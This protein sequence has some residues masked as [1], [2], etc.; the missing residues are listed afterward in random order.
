MQIRILAG[1]ERLVMA[2]AIASLIIAPAGAAAPDSKGKPASGTPLTS[3]NDGEQQVED[4]M[5]A[6]EPILYARPNSS[7]P[8]SSGPVYG[9][10]EASSWSAGGVLH[11]QVGSFDLTR[12]MP[13]LPNELRSDN[14]LDKATT[15][16]FLMQVR[17]KAFTDGTFDELK[18]AIVAHGGSIVGEMPVA[19]FLVRMTPGAHDAVKD[20]SSIV[21]LLP[22]QPAFKLSPEIGRVPLLDAVRAASSV[23]SLRLKLFPGES[24]EA[25][26]AS[27]KGLGLEVKGS[28]GD[29][30]FV[31]ADRS[32]LAAIASL[33]QVFMIEEVLPIF[34]RSEET[35][36]TVQT[37]KWN[38][39]A[40]PY[41]DAGVDGGGL[42]KTST[43]DDQILMILDNGIQLDA[44]DLSESS[45]DPGLDSNNLPIVG[46]RKVAFYGTTV[47]F[48]G[49]GDL[50]G[51]DGNTTSG[52]THGHSVAAVAL[53]NATRVLPTLSGHL[54]YGTPYRGTDTSG[55]FWGLDG[56]A[57][58]ARLVAYDGQVTPL[59]GRCDDVTQVP[60]PL[61]GLSPLY[62]GNL[63][64]LLPDAYT[65]KG[66]RVVNFSWGSVANAF[67]T[68]AGDIDAFLVSRSDA[69]VFVAA[70]NSGRD[71]DLNRI[72]D[73]NTIGAPATAKNIISV[74]AARTANDLGGLD[75]PTR[76]PLRD[77][78]NTRAVLSSNGP[79]TIFS[80]RIAPLLMAPGQDIGTMGLA[81]EFHCR[82]ND[83]N[84]YGPVEC[85]V[86]V[87]QGAGAVTGATTSYASAAAAGAGLVVRDYFAQGFYPDG[88]NTNS[89]NATDQVSTISGP[90]LKAVLV[91][92]AEW[93][94]APKSN[95]PF[96]AEAPN[97]IT[98]LTRKF[99][100]NREQGFGRIVL[101]NA[102]PL[103]TYPGA[104]S[105]LIV[106]DGGPA[107]AGLVNSTT[108]DLLAPYLASQSYALN[109]CDTSQRLAIAIAWNDP[110]I[111]D[112]I[113]R[114]LDLEVTAPSGRKYLG[115]FFTDDTDD[116]AVIA[117]NE[118][119][120]FT[121]HPWPPDSGPLAVDAGPWSLPSS[122]CTAGAH[123]DHNN[124][125]EAVFLSPDSR[126]NGIADIPGT[127]LNEA[128]DNQ[129]EQGVWNVVV[130]NGPVLAQPDAYSI[131]IAGGICLGSAA[132]IQRVLASNQLA[133]AVLSCNDSV[134][135]SIDE[136]ATAGDPIGNLTTTNIAIRT[137]LNV[138]N[139]SGAV[140]DTETLAAGDWTVVSS[141]SGNFR[142]DSK[143]I[144]L[145][146]GTTPQAGN[147]ALDVRD[148]QTVR[149]TYSDLGG[150]VRIG[151]ASVVC[152]PLLAAGGVLFNMFGK[153]AFTLVDGG[154]ENDGRLGGGN[155][156]FTF[157]YPDR[158]MDEGE[159]VSYVVAF[160]SAEAGTDLVNASISLRAV[161]ADANSPADCK[162]GSVP[163]AACTD[164][165]RADN[166]ASTFLT[167]L[168][169]PK[170]YG[171]LPAGA[172]LTPSF[173][174]QMASS[175][176]GGAPQ[177]CVNNVC[178]IDM[179][180]A[181]TAKAAGKGVES[182]IA[183]R[184]IL[185]AD[186]VDLFYSTDYPLGGAEPVG[187]FDI[188]GNEILEPITNDPKNFFN[189]YF[190]EMRTYQNM[191]STNP[192][193]TTHA[194]WN[195]DTDNG[196]FV[197]GLNNSSRPEAGTFAQWGEDKNFN[198]RLDGFCTG[199]VTIPCTQGIAA[200]VS[201]RRCTL[202]HGREC[203]VDTDCQSP[204]P[205]EGTCTA[206]GA[207]GICD[208][209]LGEDRNPAFGSLDTAWSTA[210]GCGWQSKAVGA[211][212]GGA[213]HTGLIDAPG[214]GTC[215]A[216]GLDPGD[217]QRY[218]AQP[219]GDLVGDNN[220]WELLVTPV[221][222][223]VNVCTTGNEPNCV[224]HGADAPGDPIYD[225]A[226]T[227]WAWNMSVDIPD[228]NTSVTLEFDT[229]VN[230]SQG[231]ELYNDTA[232]LSAFR[233][234][235]GAKSGG[236]G[237]ITGGFNMFQ[238]VA[239]CQDTDGNGSLD[240]CGTAAGKLC[241]ANKKKPDVECSQA[242]LG[243]RQMSSTRGLCSIPPTVKRCTGNPN[244]AC[245][246]D[247]DCNYR[248][249]LDSARACQVAGLGSGVIAGS[250]CN[251]A[252]LPGC[253]IVAGCQTASAGTCADL[254][255]N[256][257]PGNGLASPGEKCVFNPA[258]C[259]DDNPCATGTCVKTAG[260]N[261][262]GQDNCVFLGTRIP[263]AGTELVVAQE[264]YALPGPKDDDVANGY[265]NRSDGLT[266]IDKSIPCTSALHC[267]AAG[268]SYATVRS[269][270]GLTSRIC[271]NNAK[272]TALTC[273]LDSA[274]LCATSAD[275]P[276]GAGT[277]AVSAFGTCTNTVYTAVCTKPDTVVDEF[278]QKNGPGRNFGIANLNGPDMRF[279]TLEDFYGDTGTAFQAAL[280][281]NNREPDAS[282]SG[283][284]PGL[285]I[286]V[287][288]MVI[289]W[290]ETRLDTDT[291]NCVGSGEC[292]TLET[293]STLSY[294]GNSVISLTVT[295]RSPYDAVNTK[296]NCNGDTV[297]SLLVSKSCKTDTDCTTGQGTCI[298]EYSDAAKHCWNLATNSGSNA[299]CT[300]VGATCAVAGEICFAPDSTDCNDNGKLDVTVKL[301][302]EA[303]V[304][305]EIAV[306]DQIVPGSTVYKTNFPY[307]TLYNSP[308]TI[309]V[310]KSGATFPDVTGLY[311]DRNDGTNVPCKNFLEP[312]QQGFITSITTV[313]NSV[314][315]ISVTSYSVLR[316]STCTI[317]T[318]KQCVV[319]ADCVLAT[320]GTCSTA[321]GDNDGFA[322]TNELTNLVVV[323]TNKSGFDV[324]DVSAT[325]GTNSPNIEC[326]SR[327]AITI[328]ALADKVPSNPA[329]YLPFQFKVANVNRSLLTD[330]LQAKFTI[331]VRSNKFD[332][333]N[334]ATEITLDLDFN[335]S[336]GGALQPS[337]YED[338]EAGFGKFTHQ[339][340]DAAKISVPLSNGYR[341]QYNDPLG[342][343]GQSSSNTDCFL[344][345]TDDP[346]SGVNDWHI[347]T[348][349]AAMGIGRA[350]TGKQSLHLGVHTNN[351]PAEDTTGL[352]R[353]T[354]IRTVAPVNIGLA[355]A[356]PELNFA[357]QVSF[358]DNSSGV[359]VTAGEAA[360]RGVVEASATVPG[361]WIKLYPYENVYDQQGTDDFTNCVFDPVDDGNNE[362]SF[363]D[364]TDPNR[365]LGPSSTCYPEFTFV[366]H[367]QT[368][369]RKDFD[370]TDIA[371]ASDGPG[372]QPCSN[373]PS[374]LCLPANLPGVINNPGTWVRPRFS[375]VP[376]AGRSMY[377]RFLFTSIE[378]G[379]TKTMF[380]FFG[381]PNI[382]ADDGWYIDDV[383]IDGALSTA[384]TLS[385]DTPG[386]APG[387]SLACGSCGVITATLES[388]PDP[389]PSPGEVVTLT[390]KNSTADRCLNGVLQYQFWNDANGNGIVGDAA[391]VMRRDWTDNSTFVDAPV[392]T[393]QYG[394]K[395]R[396]STAP[397]C[398]GAVAANAAVKRVQVN[399]PGGPFQ[400]TI[401]LTKVAGQSVTINWPGAPASVDA[402]R[403]LLVGGPLP[404]AGKALK[405]APAGF[406]D[407]VNSCLI[408]NS[409]LPPGTN[410][411][412]ESTVLAPGD[413]FYY[414]VRGQQG[415]KY[416]SGA[417]SERG[418]P[419][420][421][422]CNAK[423]PRD[424]DLDAD[425]VADP[426]SACLPNP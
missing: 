405:T 234:T 139:S 201:C 152:R 198:G 310:V 50:L 377:F 358:V 413:G 110:S 319:D 56:V 327:S 313:N 75:N 30:V 70:G 282:T 47:P 316:V 255:T 398:G 305:G 220:W 16:H 321:Y 240:H 411:I 189:D 142:F 342:L 185:N 356:S 103:Q 141:A 370:V 297:C 28:V 309:F 199:D 249:S 29:T 270:S 301:T 221:L 426:A 343:N 247:A 338:F 60:S 302:S 138:V 63:S 294:E 337:L 145:T 55:N 102:L 345:F 37:G 84:Q 289:S 154:C 13:N 419:P 54:A 274:L 394:V 318:S 46:H 326:I 232:S 49:Q 32:Q 397:A 166:P 414:L 275:C 379:A 137:V 406:S 104:V 167:V 130:K 248:C 375:L 3:G 363:F 344:G 422:F 9:T 90:L 286:T 369:Y 312:T 39:G 226:I 27:L 114:D 229:D 404:P 150:A 91:T 242:G 14:Q 188:N 283:I 105:G 127:S 403:G 38:N 246:A 72:P 126:L 74:G 322:D 40:T 81:S 395:V 151:S 160:K 391:D 128:F 236:N 209:T 287:D 331:T 351:N 168:D 80:N 98:N 19:A 101:A 35:S 94:H 180:I 336:G 148:G 401:T 25:V 194:P 125:V 212:T 296:N 42:N 233:G 339:F 18:S 41:T 68:F 303:E 73:P 12:G 2:L 364:A 92:S 373:P 299:A 182:L 184:E 176:V 71:K 7:W 31:D 120:T 21:A 107:P 324:D 175:I 100:G 251:G 268:G 213:W 222:H 193:A 340:L 208:F 317:L 123:A 24:A 34:L 52:V 239:N 290:K 235:Q 359:N 224:G 113:T 281:F 258:W 206:P 112:Q 119:C 417:P 396:C 354:S 383:H 390:A 292:A 280:G 173:T 122:T 87:N 211:T 408:N 320:E 108:L 293:G 197:N 243:G 111:T 353:I 237:P 425:A 333:L 6:P 227:D 300:T 136:V 335:A 195:F 325:L 140:T 196:G 11:T 399:C 99:R 415:Q 147:G 129:I 421:G 134:V 416:T 252:G 158:Y 43:T 378:I 386:V 186:A 412:P 260:P 62:P 172:T 393:Q 253:A 256:V 218:W 261:R 384:I 241:N 284:A 124:N 424:T 33:D 365:R 117:G 347:H 177:N 276:A 178:K 83:N 153:D 259:D 191:T 254:T 77:T 15:Q 183:Q 230:K 88:T 118:D 400:E 5:T 374:A 392:T 402:I 380:T 44:G 273:T 76:D 85:D 26:A 45:T 163:T 106:G 277:C 181:V 349:A 250:T 86:I 366:H 228:T 57:P 350:F 174:V 190:F 362:D 207:F 170:V 51:C 36:T 257:P 64:T 329:N 382:V 238:R 265:C 97:T 291:H 203:S 78:P 95:L 210:G 204:L 410:S 262:E 157:G 144:L 1:C 285:G 352:K 407:S 311:L 161:T 225:V 323:F 146:D 295:D 231:S 315:K 304:A 59:T 216:A 69:M 423:P 159:L 93:M 192:V 155:G 278:V 263:S 267:D 61:V 169:S 164:P 133:G 372:L 269:C 115:N 214:S 131:S 328:G 389:I 409:A 171:V 360:D 179:L 279:T 376:L 215:L 307:S 361:P 66:A 381:R 205:N 121:G 96:T 385:V 368:D 272:C 20:S 244:L 67:D 388:T 355:G 330:T 348:S 58:K 4:R 53:G 314:G 245:V 23:Y 332:A 17:P 264:P 149:V 82:S 371:L 135:A 298:Q 308:G 143:K 89:G 187:G 357:H 8:F 219:D 22:Y 271:E 223:K 116:N 162:P 202:N 334:R 48:G 288:D 420:G 132:R 367:G 306:L 200:S 217:C 266:G 79:A 109:V 65:N 346:A 418:G 156:Y 341:C 165:N 387:S 10:V